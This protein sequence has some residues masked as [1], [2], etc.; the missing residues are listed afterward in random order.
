M[1]GFGKRLPIGEPLGADDTLEM[2]E[3]GVYGSSYDEEDVEAGDM[4]LLG[5]CR[6]LTPILFMVCG[7]GWTGAARCS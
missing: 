6:L 5:G 3:I 1:G 7:A 2:G 4:H